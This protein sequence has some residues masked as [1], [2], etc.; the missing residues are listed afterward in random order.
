MTLPTFAIRLAAIADA[1]LV[2][3]QRARMFRDMGRVPD[4][5]FDLYRTRCEAGLREMIESGE[6]VG[7]LASPPDQP[8]QIVAGAGVQRRRVLPH[9]AGEAEE[10]ST[11][12]EGRHAIIINVF[13][14][15]AWRRRRLATLLLREIIAWSRRERLDR[16]VLHAS[17]EG[18]LVYERLGF[19]STNEMRFQGRLDA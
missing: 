3:D 4:D 6:Y 16:L 14:E 5:L 7:W 15:P 8:D 11:I 9:P 1:P 2:A 19:A 17:D 13:T 10:K 12:A 18:R